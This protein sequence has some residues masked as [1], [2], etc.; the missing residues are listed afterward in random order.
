MD[1]VD[2]SEKD[3]LPSYLSSRVSSRL[4]SLKSRNHDE[5]Q[6]PR[7]GSISPRFLS[8]NEWQS[9]LL[10]PCSKNDFHD[11]R[12]CYDSDS[13]E[14]T[15]GESPPSYW[16]TSSKRQSRPLLKLNFCSCMPWN[17]MIQDHEDSPLK[18][19]HDI[20]TTRTLT[21]EG[22]QL[23][24]VFRVTEQERRLLE[25]LRCNVE[26]RFEGR[27][28]PDPY[29]EEYEEYEEDVASSNATT[30]CEVSEA[31]P[32]LPK[33]DWSYSVCDARKLEST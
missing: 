23:V 10:D 18:E 1:P 21:T 11:L 14:S 15:Q 2:S 22:P 20:T 19:S 12:K 17:A 29:Y 27:V 31:L 32:E 3:S 26:V 28:V 25:I 4:Q 6:S 5:A 7:S 8:E 33:N 13:L 24:E 9:Q 16:S 30:V